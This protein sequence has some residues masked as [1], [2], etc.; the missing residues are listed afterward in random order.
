MNKA[1]TWDEYVY[2]VND[3]LL[4]SMQPILT[5][6]DSNALELCYNSCYREL[7]AAV[8]ILTDRKYRR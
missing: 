8:A 3:I 6:A 4:G 2:A 1:Y 7:H 5:Q